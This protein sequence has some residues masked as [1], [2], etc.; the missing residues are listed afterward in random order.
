MKILLFGMAKEAVGKSSIE[1]N[2]AGNITSVKEL[3]QR[4]LE[5]FPQF[6]QLPPM[7]VAVNTRYARDEDKV[8]EGD[9]VVLIPPVS[10]G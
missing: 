10:G 4:L 1:L 7:G 9:E 2:D 6:G 5:D 8:S 3:K